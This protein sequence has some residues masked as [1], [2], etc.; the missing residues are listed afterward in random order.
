MVDS[1]LKNFAEFKN[2]VD[3]LKN[4]FSKSFF[5]MLKEEFEKEVT[6]KKDFVE[7]CDI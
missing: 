7:Y 3:V 6:N 4:V 1:L 2:S 5:K